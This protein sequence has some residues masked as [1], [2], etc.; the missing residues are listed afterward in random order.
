MTTE[1]TRVSD[2]ALAAQ[3]LA[4]KLLV[5]A[6]APE[7]VPRPRLVE[8]L[9]EATRRRVTVVAAPA[10]FGKTT[11]VAAWIAET[12]PP[13]AWLS[14]D[15]EDNEL[16][17]FLVHLVGAVRSRWPEV[18]DAALAHLA[19]PPLRWTAVL[20]TLLNDLAAQGTPLTLVLDEL[21]VV[22]SQAVLEA[23]A[24]LLDY[25][26]PNLHL[27]LCTR[28]EPRLPLPRLRARAQL[29]EVTADDLRFTLDESARFLEQAMALRLSPQGRRTLYE[30]TEGWIT[31]LQLA[32]LS[33]RRTADSDRFIATFAGDHRHVADYLMDEVLRRQPPAVQE[34]LFATSVLRRLCGEL[35][36]AVAGGSGGDALLE[37]LAESNLFVQRLDEQRRWYR[38]HRLFAE[39]LR[40]R[41]QAREPD[42][43][44]ALHR[45]AAAWFDDRGLVPEAIHHALA[46][47]DTEL[48][49]R[50]VERHGNV[51]LARGE[52]RAVFEWLAALPDEAFAQRP[53]LG[54]F[55]AVARLAARDVDGAARRLSAVEQQL[56]RLQA[57]PPALI[58]FV[59]ILAAM[60]CLFRDEIGRAMELAVETEAMAA[61]LPPALAGVLEA[62]LALAHHARGELGEARIRAESGLASGLAQGNPRAVLH[63]GVLLARIDLREGR[64]RRAEASCRELLDLAVKNGWWEV[65]FRTVPQLALAEALYERDAL[66]EAEEVLESAAELAGRLGPDEHEDLA[67]E[68]LARV[69]LAR[70]EAV[71]AAGVEPERAAREELHLHLFEP[72]A[73]HRLCW[74]LAAGEAVA[75]E[76]ELRR[77]GLDPHATAPD[78]GR[79]REYL[80]LARALVARGRPAEALP[81]LAR[82]LLAA[83]AGGRRGT[84]LEALCLQAVARHLQ[85]SLPQAQ[86]AL[87]RAL[88]LAGDEG[89][90]RVFVDLGP[91]MRH[92]LGRAAAAGTGG[93]AAERL[94]AA[95]GEA[96]P[97]AATAVSPLAEPIR[98]RELDVLRCIAAGMSNP[99]IAGHLYLSPNTVKTHV[100]NLYAKL[101]VEKRSQALR[102]AR[103][104][105]LISG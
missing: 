42:A 46:G 35:C 71:A 18:G 39:L 40:H 38:Y 31:G 13:V 62:V 88:E 24:Y 95:F 47:G 36:D 54:A 74:R 2:D 99:E 93:A 66:L 87:Q 58:S 76:A 85:G 8:H 77:R 41:L 29:A 6:L 27:V 48:A 23:V 32:A 79:E 44:P 103:E 22:Q 82:L 73:Y 96:P 78:P 100:R 52:H 7:V 34:F 69:R 14:L 70:G 26:P 25:Q 19:R 92:L 75:V 67:A 55:D 59:R 61:E 97:A 11:A 28:V 50:L 81:L 101:G 57:P 60:V 33:L 1:T 80:L 49:S 104:L 94:L 89:W 102:R 21:E 20:G 43:V 65:S 86:E 98:E 63:L 12:R 105:G 90:V 84:A 91:P 51:L 5:P 64:L 9:T 4:T 16:G 3:L 53:Q 72:P 45:R 15:E 17:R 37:Q 30:R 68:W 83:E 56:A 10:G